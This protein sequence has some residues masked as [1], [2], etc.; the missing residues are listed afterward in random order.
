[1]I[2]KNQNLKDVVVLTTG[3]M[4]QV[5]LGF[6]TLRLITELLSEEDVG[7]YYTLLTVVSLLAF[8]FFN[9]LGQFYGRNLVHWQQSR[10][11]RNATVMMLLLRMMAMPFAL[12]VA[13]LCFYTF[14]YNKYFSIFSYS[15][16]MV[17]AILALTHGILL[18]ATNVLINRVTFIA[19]TVGTLVLG[20]IASLLLVQIN[21][22][23]MNWLYGLF[24]TQIFISYFLYKKITAGQ[25]LSVPM[26][27]KSVNREY[28][29]RVLFFILP[30]SL[31]LFLQWGQTTSF[32][33]IVEDLYSARA[34]ASI[35]VGMAVS[36]AI[37]SA[38]ETLFQQFYMPVYLRKI[39]SK[40]AEKRADA[41][42]ELARALLPVYVAVT[43]YVI[44]M[45]PALTQLLVADK[46]HDSYVYAM[47]GACIELLRVTTNLTYMVSQSE[48]KTK[49]TV[50][51]YLIG[52]IVM[53]TGLLSVDVSGSL[54][55]V[56]SILVVSYMMVQALMYLNMRRLLPISIDVRLC[57]R[58]ALMASPLLFAM[59]FV[60][61][62][63][64]AVSILVLALGGIYLLSGLYF[65][66]I[67]HLKKMAS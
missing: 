18:N 14:D 11:V 17:V 55:I 62:S 4:I 64:L 51:P 63:S 54:W 33:L 22:T 10:N 15:I 48:I 16:F 66:Q 13:V 57:L 35:A 19:F 32:R 38:L 39:T 9:P 50:M 12:L 45:S 60:P 24:G 34:L 65:L 27:K 37:F 67:D 29:T 52:F 41:W 8:V 56:P 20:F 30:V 28:V 7:V 59:G 1:M 25:P 40:P 58:S 47:I 36:S 5:L 44:A 42:N 26:M 43:I 49:T 3:K 31:T 21:E 61:D 6:A 2:F 23:A 46:F 53:V